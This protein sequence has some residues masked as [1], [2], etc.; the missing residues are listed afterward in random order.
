[1]PEVNQVLQNRYRIEAQLGQGGM[2]AVYRAYDMRLQRVC[3]VKELLLQSG[4]ARDMSDAAAQFFQEARTLS[5]LHHPAL[6]RV[7]DH[8]EEGGVAFLVM[9]FISGKNLG[10]LIGTGLPEDTVLSYADQLLDVLDYIHRQGVLHRDIKPTNIIIQPDGHVA[11]VDFGLVK[12]VSGTTQLTKPFLRGIGTPEY[13]PPEQYSGG[14]DQRSD[15]YSL[16]GTLYNA[17][18][19]QAPASA[20]NQITGMPLVPPRQFGIK[21][22]ANTERA[23]LRSLSLN[24]AQR[25]QNAAEFRAALR[26][27]APRA[28]AAPSPTPTERVASPGR[29]GTDKRLVGAAIVGGVMLIVASLFVVMNLASSPAAEAIGTATNIG[30]VTSAQSDT[31]KQTATLAAVIA[32]AATITLVPARTDSPTI[33]VPTETATPTATP[34]PTSEPTPSPTPVKPTCQTGRAEITS[35]LSGQVING[36]VTVR[37]TADC[38]GFAFYKFEFVDSRCAKGLCF[39][40]GEFRQPVVDGILMQWDTRKTWDGQNMPN[41]TFVLRMTVLGKPSPLGNVLPYAPEI[42]IT[43]DN[44]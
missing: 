41:D 38:D 24:P 14:T 13:A 3:V 10:S 23:I 33:I 22:S 8:F 20:T 25:F 34:T 9:D 30:A 29:S 28:G 6:P 17:L 16:G 12:S 4:F 31:A 27:T 39:V 36:V 32:E 37:G 43:I 44:R 15:I 42:R 1:M 40:A 35:P 18:T 21:L 5:N 11:L 19:G 26:G 2:G 7:I